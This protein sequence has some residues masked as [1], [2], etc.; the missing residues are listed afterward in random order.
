MFLSFGY[1]LP[2]L[3][4]AEDIAPKTM[5]HLRVIVDSEDQ[6]CRLKLELAALIDCGKHF[7]TATYDLE[8]DG[9]LVLGCYQRMQIVANACQVGVGQMH[10]PNLQAVAADLAATYAGVTVDWAKG[11]GRD[12]VRPAVQWF[13]R[14]FN[15]ELYPLMRVFKAARYFCP[16]TVRSLAPTPATVQN[17][18]SFPF[19]DDDG[20][21]DNLTAELPHYLAAAEDTVFCG[22]SIKEVSA[23][24]VEWW[25]DHAADLPHWSA[26]M[27]KVLLVQPSSAAA[28]RV[29]SLL[30]AA[31]GDLQC[32]ALRDYI[33]CS[34]ML[35]YN[36]RS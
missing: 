22:E 31:F 21:L 13:M 30:K 1:L 16:A 14:K 12:R 25:R 10:F 7:V 24:K 28:E 29:F 32:S 36:Q 34:L 17:L 20:I 8:G 35:R 19:L 4:A 27:K 23:K 5:D 3:D 6:L 11:Y 26:A 15:V 2:F 18:R 9:A 33:E